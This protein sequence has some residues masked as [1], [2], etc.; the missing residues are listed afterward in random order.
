MSEPPPP[1]I[2]RMLES[3]AEIQ[4]AID[5]LLLRATRRLDIF[6]PRLGTSWDR[7][8]RIERLRRFCLGGDRNRIRIALH[9]TGS[10]VRSTPRLR[11]LRE[12]FGHVLFVRST[13]DEARRAN[14]PLVIADG[15][16]YLHRLHVDSSRSV[17]G[18]DD[19]EGAN[20]LLERY[21]Q[22]W[23]ASEDGAAGTTLGL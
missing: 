10:I 16:H 7:P 23:N 15:R 3:E 21:E 18:I 17:F 14:D 2:R 12:S 1:V 19:P 11:G 6:E 8:D 4:Q 9:D 22:I 13:C 20:L 5:E